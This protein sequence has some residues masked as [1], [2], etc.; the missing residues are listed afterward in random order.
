MSARIPQVSQVAGVCEREE[1]RE[2]SQGKE[3]KESKGLVEVMTEKK[4]L[5]KESQN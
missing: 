4:Q 2:K 5:E 1:E 3:E